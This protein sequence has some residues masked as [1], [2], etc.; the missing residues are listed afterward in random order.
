MKITVRPFHPQDAEATVAVR[1]AAVPHLVGTARSLLWETEQRPEHER[2]RLIAE[3]HGQ[4]GQH[5]QRPQPGQ[6]AESA[7]SAETGST[8]PT[9]RTGRPGPTE[10]AEPAALLGR[11]GRLGH[12][13]GRTAEIRHSGHAPPPGP[14][15][16]APGGLVGCADI[17]LIADSGTPGQG[18]VQTMVLPAA[19]RAGV[20]GALVA[21]AEERLRAMGAVRAHTWAADDGVAP[22]FAERRGYRCLRRARILGLDLATARLPAPPAPLP[23]GVVLCTPAEVAGEAGDLRPLYEADVECAADEPG[24]AASVRLPYEVWLRHN[25]LRPDWD[26]RLSSVVLVDGAVA[27]YSVAQTDGVDRCWS[28]MT[29]TR[30]AFRGRGLAALAKADSLRRSRA[31]GYRHAFTGNDAANAAMLGI[32][33]RL[34]YTVVASQWRCA[35][36]L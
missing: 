9:G 1:R 18:F 14:R 31:A 8:G 16:A 10:P 32:N 21:A 12:R 20:G 6:P 3:Q 17:G 29:G 5:G 7:E 26:A 27:A 2:Y 23:E 4:P 22:D 30:R 28:G 11:L 35:K 19:Q 25:W 34:G 13:S 24:A 36:T 33:R 15:T